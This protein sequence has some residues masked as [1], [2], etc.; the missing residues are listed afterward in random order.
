[1]FTAYGIWAILKVPDQCKQC[2][3]PSKSMNVHGYVVSLILVSKWDAKKT[4][5]PFFIMSFNSLA[6]NLVSSTS[7]KAQ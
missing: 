2:Q 6:I 7:N 4:I 5:P 1:M 3:P